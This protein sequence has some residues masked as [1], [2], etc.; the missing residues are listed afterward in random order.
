[1][2]EYAE[3]QPDWDAQD[4]PNCTD[5]CPSHDGKRCVVLGFRPDTI[6]EPAVIHLMHRDK[7]KEPRTRHADNG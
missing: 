6:C 5:T 7:E 3:I 4:V 1:M 2:S